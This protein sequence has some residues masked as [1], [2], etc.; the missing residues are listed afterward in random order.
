[1]MSADAA[2]SDTRRAPGDRNSADETIIVNGLSIELQR[3]G[4][5]PALMF[6]HAHLGLWRSE[7]FIDALA[8]RFDV[9]APSH[10]GFGASQVSPSITTVDD[11]GYFYLD[12]IEQLGLEKLTVVGASL[13]GWI[14]LSMAI[15]DC[16]RIASLVL[17]NP[18]GLHF[19]RPDEESVVDIFS[20]DETAFSTRGF[21]N[22]ALGC[23]DY[24]SMDDGELL[25]SSRNR[26]AAARYAWSPCFYDPKLAGW[27]PRIKRPVHLL[28][29]AEDRL[30]AP[31]YGLQ[32]AKAMPHADFREIAGA[33]HFPHI[34]RPDLVAEMVDQLVA[35]AA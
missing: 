13:G 3:R 32:I 31:G 20:L 34:E 14:A 28:W 2:A 27:L 17:L 1:M 19:G 7:P 18:V 25:I 15:K 23:K 24:A 9:I 30:T 6:L 5:G 29:G 4:S 21:A 33:G 35:A 11:L 8:A 16:S 26:E 12:L 10:P 22:P